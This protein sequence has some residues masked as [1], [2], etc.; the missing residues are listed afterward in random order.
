M[1]LSEE[2][3][4]LECLL[5]KRKFIKFK[6]FQ[7]I[8]SNLGQKV[9]DTLNSIRCVRGAKFDYVYGLC[10]KMLTNLANKII[11]YRTATVKSGLYY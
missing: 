10:L 4:A 2:K 11:M 1:T 5:M 7:H 6:I 9:W 8:R 3:S